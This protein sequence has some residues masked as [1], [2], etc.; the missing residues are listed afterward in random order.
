MGQDAAP[1]D[2]FKA[3]V[4]TEKIG[5]GFRPCW[6]SKL[7]VDIPATSSGSDRTKAEAK[8]DA[9]EAARKL[10]ITIEDD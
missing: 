2:R 5:G 7:H 6:V 10:G 8:A 1:K 9:Q 3:T 4:T